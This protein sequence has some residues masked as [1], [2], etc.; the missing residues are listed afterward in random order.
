MRIKSKLN[1]F[2]GGFVS[3]P[4]AR[5]AVGLGRKVLKQTNPELS[6]YIDLGLKTYVALTSGNPNTCDVLSSKKKRVSS[7]KGLKLEGHVLKMTGTGS[8]TNTSFHAKVKHRFKTPKKVLGLSQES[9]LHVDADYK[10]AGAYD[11]QSIY[12]MT[13][14][15]SAGVGYQ[16]HNAIWSGYDNKTLKS[17]ACNEIN[18]TF[19][20]MFPTSKV[21]FE[22]CDVETVIANDSPVMIFVDIYELVAKHDMQSA[23]TSPYTGN[24][25]YSPTIYWSSGM[26]QNSAASVPNAT[27]VNKGLTLATTVGAKPWESED[28]NVYWKICSQYRVELTAGAQHRHFSHYILDMPISDRRFNISALMGGITR[29]IMLVF[30]GSLGYDAANTSAEFIA[31]Q[32]TVRHDIVYKSFAMPYSQRIDYY[33]QTEATGAA[34]TTKVEGVDTPS[35]IT[36]PTGF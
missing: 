36:N 16:F 19:S 33:Y 13:S 5:R 3:K 1:R 23:G 22:R 14:A 24:A 26:S 9:L 7:V 15:T 17:G 25:V 4:F 30:Q 8:V 6:K 20:T 21:V 31:A 32:A 29:N 35:T 11:Q 34:A 10:V 2:R 18:N 28:F 27:V 12:D